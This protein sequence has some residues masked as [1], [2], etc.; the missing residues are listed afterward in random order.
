MK[1]IGD[2]HAAAARDGDD[3]DPPVVRVVDGVDAQRDPPDERREDERE[4]RGRRRRR[5]RMYGSA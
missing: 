2:R 5:A 3:V 4:D 1:A